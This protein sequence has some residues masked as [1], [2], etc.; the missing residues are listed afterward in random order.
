M[1]SKILPP[2]SIDYVHVETMG[3]DKGRSFFGKRL[4]QIGFAVNVVPLSRM[5]IF[6][7]S[8]AYRRLCF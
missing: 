5:R 7:R 3:D 4:D 2:S 1:A 6:Q 8:H